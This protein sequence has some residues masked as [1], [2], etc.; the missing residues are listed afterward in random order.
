MDI[1]LRVGLIATSRMDG[2]PK[3]DKVSHTY[4]TLFHEGESGNTMQ[5]SGRYRLKY[6]LSAK[7]FKPVA[8][9]TVYLVSGCL[10]FSTV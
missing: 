2:F 8:Y 10:R 3:A 4:E 7:G 1:Y 6:E 9:L 5:V